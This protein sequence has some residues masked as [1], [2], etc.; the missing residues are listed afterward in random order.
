M[1]HELGNLLATASTFRRTETEHDR[2]NNGPILY[3]MDVQD[4]PKEKQQTLRT[5]LS[6]GP[7]SQLVFACA[8]RVDDI[9]KITGL[10][11]P[12][13]KLARHLEEHVGKISIE[14][15]KFI[16]AGV[17]HEM[18]PEG[19]YTHQ[20]HY[21]QQIQP[22]TT[23]HLNNQPADFSLSESDRLTYLSLLGAILINVLVSTNTPRLGR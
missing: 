22:A 6:N 3:Y 12:A 21:I 4:L 14:S 20:T 11:E 9:I 18:K 13:A 10:S 23:S 2:P 5:M 16:H 17:A 8:M 7:P 1:P 19:L 15:E